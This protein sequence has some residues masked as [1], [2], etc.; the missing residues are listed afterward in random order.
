MP[1]NPAMDGRPSC[2]ND[3]G[4]T[5]TLHPS[6]WR[7]APQSTAIQPA[8]A[9]DGRPSCRN[10]GGNNPHHHHPVTPSPQP[11]PTFRRLITPFVAGW[12]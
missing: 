7:A 6:L 11:T 8:P 3:G 5:T 4:N 9:M 2:R 12:G 10:D 1:P